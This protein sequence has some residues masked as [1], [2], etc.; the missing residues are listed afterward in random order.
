MTL[1]YYNPLFLEHQT[2]MHPERPSRLARIIRH[3]EELKLDQRCER[4]AWQ[5]ATDDQLVR[6]HCPEYAEEVRKLAAM[7]GGQI[8]ADTFVSAKSYDA[9]RLASGAACDAVRQVLAGKAQNAL[10]LVRPPGHHALQRGAMGFCL[11]NHVAVAARCALQEFQVRRVLIIDW[12]VHHGNG[13]QD[14]FYE[15]GQVGFYSI[16]RSP[17]YPGT[18]AAD[19]TGTGPGLGMIRNVPM[20]FG[21]SREA[22]HAA[23]RS[24]VEKFAD[25]VRPELVLISAGFDAHRL[26]PIGSLGLETEDYAELTKVV[27][28][29]AD[30]HA[31]GRVVSL[32]EGGYNID[33]LPLCVA[34]HLEGLLAAR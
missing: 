23:F 32:L 1:L 33:V 21:G 8:E 6:V 11:F 9:A 29:I 24:T 4:P 16:H 28:Q 2:G 18:G 12:D 14:A 13:T 17:F 31:R 5:P 7:G 27:R 15:D 26:D 34:T 19:E 20:K 22:F 3:L 25:H 10:C 30:Q